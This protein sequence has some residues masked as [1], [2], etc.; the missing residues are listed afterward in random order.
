[1]RRLS[2]HQQLEPA[3]PERLDATDLRQLCRIR[4]HERVHLLEVETM[5]RMRW[6]AF[7]WG[8]PSPVLHIA[9]FHRQ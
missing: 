4:L 1:M 2:T 7:V 9:S 8:D 6:P 3:G 5:G